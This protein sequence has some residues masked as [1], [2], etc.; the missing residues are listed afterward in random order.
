MRI[1][2]ID[3]FDI[4]WYNIEKSKELLIYLSKFVWRCF[5]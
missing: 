1:K 5:L 3:K 2:N 4:L